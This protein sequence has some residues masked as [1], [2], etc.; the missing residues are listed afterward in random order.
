M[1]VVDTASAGGS[2]LQQQQQAAKSAEPADEH[3]ESAPV[4]AATAAA[5]SSA[6][7]D[8]DSH[9]GREPCCGTKGVRH[10]SDS[11]VTRLPG[12]YVLPAADRPGAGLCGRVKLPVVDL[13]RLRE[14]SG[15]AAALVTLDAACRG[16]G[17]FQVVNHG[18]ERRVAGAMLD[19]A[20][21]FFEL[22]AAERERYASPDVRAAVRHGTSFNQARDA[23]LFWR[24]F[25][26]LACQPLG[27]VAPS[28]P[29]APADLREAASEYAT[30]SNGLFMEL[31]AAALEA[32]GVHAGGGGLL[33]ELAAGHSQIMMANCYPPCPQPELTLGLPP[34]SDYGLLTLLLQDQ[35]VEGLQVMHGGRWLAVDP[36]PGSLI[37]NVGDQ[38]EIYSNGQYRSV[39]HRVLV[40]ST[41]SRF[42]VASFHCLPAERMIGPAAE[43]VDERNP[44]RY[45]D[46]S[47][48]TF[49]A[50]LSAGKHSTFLQSRKL[51]NDKNSHNCH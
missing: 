28:W 26:K 39:L 44:R 40:N 12:R 20:R 19:V 51:I 24:D 43:L 2:Q 22:P 30:A 17:F 13:A 16:Y 6:V 38:F 11:G 35:D 47:F 29:D 5:A 10:L 33:G 27:D 31:M 41:R 48:G 45:M 4:A 37:V 36:V 32:L 34:H 8:V 46:T 42:S 50:H 14:P 18:V 9:S 25:L 23:V 21:R 7:D 15:R 49:L 1:A 3:E